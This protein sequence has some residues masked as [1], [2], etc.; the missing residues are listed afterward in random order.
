MDRFSAYLLVRRH[1]K[2]PQ[3]RNQALAAEALMEEFARELGQP[4][5]RW[6]VLGMLGQLDLEYAEQNP[7]VRG[8]TAREQAEMEGIAPHEAEHLERWCGHLRPPRQDAASELADVEHALGLATTL[9][10]EALQRTDGECAVSAVSLAHDL[11][12]LSQGG[13]ARG[14]QLDR[15]LDRLSLTAERAA[16]LCVAALQRIAQDLR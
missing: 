7:E 1:L 15:A 13:D 11:E 10:E 2:R 4:Q 8:R 3:S 6:G 12:L 14:D 5:D 16:E 9:A